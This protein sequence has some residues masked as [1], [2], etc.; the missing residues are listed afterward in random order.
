HMLE[1]SDLIK[2]VELEVGKVTSRLKDRKIGITL[3]QSALDYLI[4]EG[5]DP[6]Y[7]ARPMRRAVERHM[8]DP[9]AELLLRG[10]VNEGDT[11]V[12]TRIDDEKKLRFDVK[13]S[14]PGSAPEAETVVQEG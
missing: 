11:I 3:E 1:K 8:E 4:E 7:G 5:Y 9:L 2:I 14:D 12:A 10:E 6:M 13:A